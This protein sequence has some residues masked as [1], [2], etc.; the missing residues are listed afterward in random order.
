MKVIMVCGKLVRNPVN[1]VLV[2]QLVRAA[3]SIGANYREANDVFSKKDF[4]YKIGISLME[5]KEAH[6]W[7]NL[8]REAN[9]NYKEIIWQLIGES[10][11]LRKIF[12]SIVSKSY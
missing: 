1:D 6:Y 12:S 10:C 2:R 8:L 9:I 7:L 4:R 5:A 11:E 3:G